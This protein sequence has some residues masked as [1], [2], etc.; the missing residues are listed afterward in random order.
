V[1]EETA[2]AYL[3]H[4]FAG[5]VHESGCIVLTTDGEE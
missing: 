4:G 5:R 1:I 2:T 3:D